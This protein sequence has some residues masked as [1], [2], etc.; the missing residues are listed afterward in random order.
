MG[1]GKLGVADNGKDP[2]FVSID[3]LSEH[4]NNLQGITQYFHRPRKSA[5]C[6][7]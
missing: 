7:W 2:E 1:Y 6:K 3:V 4:E 5:V